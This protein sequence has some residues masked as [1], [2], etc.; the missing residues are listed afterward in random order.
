MVMSWD[1]IGAIAEIIGAFAVVITLIYLSVQLRDNTASTRASTAQAFAD[2]INS[3]NLVLVGD[4][5]LARIYRIG[6]FG[7]WDS[8]NDDEKFQWS[9][10]AISVCRSLEVALTLE[11]LKQGDAQTVTLAKNTLKKLFEEESYR[12]WWR[13]GHDS[14]PFTDD[15]IEFIEQECL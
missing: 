3:S 15:F 8:L 11:R 6:K 14:L 10:L 1:A 7:D 4:A 12:R 2:S 13:Q 5:S 9:R